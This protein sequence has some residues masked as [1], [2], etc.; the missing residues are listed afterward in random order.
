MTDGHKPEQPDDDEAIR[1]EGPAGTSIRI[2]ASRSDVGPYIKW[3]VI[4][5]AFT[6]AV[7]G[8]GGCI[9]LILGGL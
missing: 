3:V 9:R 4:A 7:L 5:I 1:A 8:I 2:P 6:I